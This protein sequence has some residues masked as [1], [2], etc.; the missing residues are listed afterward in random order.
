MGAPLLRQPFTILIL[1]FLSA[2]VGLLLGDYVYTNQRFPSNTFIENLDVSGLKVSEVILQL[3]GADVDA[4]SLKFITLL[5]STEGYEYAPSEIGAYIKPRTSAYEAFKSSYESS[6]FKGILR[7]VLGERRQLVLPLQLGL[8]EDKTK[9]VL[10]EVAKGID[11]PSLEAHCILLG[12]GR[13]RLTKEKLGKGVGIDETIT[14]L[15]D[16]FANGKR[17]APLIVKVV[18][19]RILKRNLVSRPPVRSI[20]RYQT[21]YG[22]HDS[23]NRIHNIKLMSSVLNNYIILSGETFSL[24]DVIGEISE[25][26]GY[27]EAMVIVGGELVPQ[28][29]GG[30][31]QVATTLYNAAMLADLEIVQRKNHAIYFFIYPLGRDAAI[32]PGSL[33]LKFKNNTG[34]PIMLRLYVTDKDLTFAIYGTPAGKSVEF[35]SPKIIVKK[36]GLFSYEVSQEAFGFDAPFSTV[37]KR[38]VSI[39]DKVIKEEKIKSYYKY[40]GEGNARVVR[41]ELEE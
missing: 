10:K 12:G 20:A 40:A 19:P 37:V 18:P 14:L 31:C 25:K 29:G 24:L 16:A 21:Q 28:Y 30:T 4:T 3:E 26:E 35:S 5:S 27:K 22:Y 6:Y 8:D 11:A 32:Y 39:G 36:A 17:T 33:D 13:Y 7:R 15:R 34:H 1:I 23:E 41:Q 2:A 38:A 9:S